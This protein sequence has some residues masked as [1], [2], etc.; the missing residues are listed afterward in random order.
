MNK[1]SIKTD[2]NGSGV[3]DHNIIKTKQH[4][5]II[6]NAHYDRF[7]LLP[8][9]VPLLL[10]PFLVF[11]GASKSPTLPVVVNL[12]DLLVFTLSP[13]SPSPTSDTDADERAFRVGRAA[14]FPGGAVDR[15]GPGNGIT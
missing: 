2:S 5:T 14:A 13:V 1:S 7:F 11:T 6:L 4:I 8:A 10:V 12:D 9:A 3:I 15:G